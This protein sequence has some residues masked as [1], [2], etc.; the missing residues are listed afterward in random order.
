[1]GAKHLLTGCESYIDE[2]YIGWSWEQWI[3]NFLGTCHSPL[4]H[5]KSELRTQNCRTELGDSCWARL[6]LLGP[7]LWGLALLK[8]P[9]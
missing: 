8:F 4:G 3:Q 9:S 2:N 7:E 1:M 6:G 5:E